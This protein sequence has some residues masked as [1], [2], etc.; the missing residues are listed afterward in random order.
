MSRIDGE[1]VGRWSLRLDAAYCAV[2]GVVVLATVP[3]IASTLEL[4]HGVIG[5]I[6][7]AT[8]LW[9]A[10]IVG[11]VARLRLGTA[12]R[13]VVAANVLAAIGVAGVSTVAVTAIVAV[14]VL[15]VA[16]DVALFAASQV[17]ALRSLSPA[18]ST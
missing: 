14:A 5:G 10:V 2:L 9:A 12:L 6:G 4:P 1:R 3:E 17:I 15:T 8:V 18:A 11:V 16:V 13:L 7:I